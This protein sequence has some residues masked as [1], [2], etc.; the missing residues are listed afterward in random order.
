MLAGFKVAVCSASPQ[1]K[2]KQ[3][4][5]THKKNKR[6]SRDKITIRMRLSNQQLFSAF[7]FT[8]ELVNPAD[9]FVLSPR[10][11]AQSRCLI[12]LLQIAPFFQQFAGNS[13]L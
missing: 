11:T 2:T 4:T 9:C 12:Y 3:H 1:D 8:G 6:Q 13:Q 10:S 5:H 7:P